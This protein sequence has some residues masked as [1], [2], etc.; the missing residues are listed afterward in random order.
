MLKCRTGK[1]IRRPRSITV[2][3]WGSNTNFRGVCLRECVCVR[4][5][6][7]KRASSY[8]GPSTVSRWG[9]N[10]N[11]RGVFVLERVGQRETVRDTERQRERYKE[12]L[13]ETEREKERDRYT[14]IG[15]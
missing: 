9:S 13:R 4:E 1:D 11:F 14:P 12:R 3:R 15:R 7:I 2:S 6:E 8:P 5:R 10:T